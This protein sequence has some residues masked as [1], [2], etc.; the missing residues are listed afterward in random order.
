LIDMAQE[1]FALKQLDNS[2]HRAVAFDFTFKFVE[3]LS[4]VFVGK[5]LIA[6]GKRHCRVLSKS[7]DFSGRLLLRF[8]NAMQG[9]DRIRLV[10]RQAARN[11]LLAQLPRRHATSEREIV[12]RLL[13]GRAAAATGED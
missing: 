9:A 5:R 7:S 3:H 2:G 1:R 13:G 11:E 8:L 6:T 12:D 4:A 10:C